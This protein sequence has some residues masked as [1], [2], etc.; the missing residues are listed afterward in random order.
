MELSVLPMY[1]GDPL[2]LTAFNV[3]QWVLPM[4]MGVILRKW[5]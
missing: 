5:L 4:Y 3:D 2:L 1:G